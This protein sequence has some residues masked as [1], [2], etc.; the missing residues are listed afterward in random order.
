MTV[1]DRPILFSAPM[2][3]AILAGQKT[4]TRRAVKGFALELLGP[5]NFTPEY[6]ALP[7]NH[8]CP[9]GVPGDRLWVR[10]TWAPNDGSAGGHL[11]RA[12]HDAASGYHKLDLK[13]GVWTHSVSRWR[14]SIHMP[15]AVSRITL[16][17]T[18]VRV[19]RLQ[20]ISE[21]DATAEG[22]ETW[23]TG[24]MS[25][26]GQRDYSAIGKFERLW[27][28]ING[29]ESWHADPFVWVVEFKRA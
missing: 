6:V 25:P 20:E 17:I 24:A 11:Y 5:D 18:G 21:A 10:E 8:L 19:E 22:V 7:E 29:I 16:E 27:S 1:T 15:R 3:R 9:Y 26:E 4:Q 28:S 14:P 13:T 12:D 2:V 23:A